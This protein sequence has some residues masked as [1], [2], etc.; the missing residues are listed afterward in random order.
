[1]CVAYSTTGAQYSNN[2]GYVEQ[3]RF[4]PLGAA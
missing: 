4:V 2:G 3:M 1:M